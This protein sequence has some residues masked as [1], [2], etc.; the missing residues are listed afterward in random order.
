M[1][2]GNVEQHLPAL[3]R[4]VQREGKQVLWSSDPMHGN[5]MK[6]SSVYKTR[7][8]ARILTEVQ[9]FFA[10]HHAEGSCAGGIH[11]E[12]TGQN[13]T[14]YIGC[15]LPITKSVVTERNQTQCD[16]LN[17]AYQCIHRT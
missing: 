4:A 17:N 16:A 8:F 6:A 3:I 9:Q 15:S 5:T 7:D 1:G 10:G 2:A 14:K 13:G 11:I 12:M